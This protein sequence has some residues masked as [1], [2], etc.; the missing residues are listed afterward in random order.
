MKLYLQGADF[1]ILP[2]WPSFPG[3]SVHLGAISF[4]LSFTLCLDSDFCLSAVR[5][6]VC[7]SCFQN[8]PWAHCIFCDLLPQL[9]FTHSWFPVCTPGWGTS[10]C[11]INWKHPSSGSMLVTYLTPLFRTQTY[12]SGPL[13]MASFLLRAFLQ[14]FISEMLFVVDLGW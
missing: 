6:Q 11:S 10:Y 13:L 3:C 14:E 1:L 7:L 8:N 5:H 2:S 9:C 12:L 4:F